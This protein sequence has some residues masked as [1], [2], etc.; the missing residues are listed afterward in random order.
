M[1]PYISDSRAGIAQHRR[2]VA[3][4]MSHGGGVGTNG[5]TLR[6]RGAIAKTV[7]GRSSGAVS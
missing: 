3:E 1:L 6:P 7:G 4:I 5:S 2:E